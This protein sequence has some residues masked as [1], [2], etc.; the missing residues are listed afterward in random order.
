[1]DFAT[2]VKR[3]LPWI[4][5]AAT[6]NVPALIT[7]A[8]Q[9]VGEVLGVDVPADADAITTAVANATPEQLV[10]LRSREMDFK[11]RMQGLG[12]QQEREMRAFDI[13]ETKALIEDTTSARGAFGS[14]ENVFTLGC[15]I[16]SVFGLLMALVLTGCFFLMTGRVTVDSGTLAVCAGLIGTVVGYVAANAQQV[17]SFFYGS[18]KGSKDSGDRIGAALTES[19]KQQGSK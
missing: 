2:V 14:N 16:L 5:A 1:M 3:A 4:G 9:A 11:E 10:S 18:S 15:I 13:E 12:F 7:L 6:S 19:I 8:A 17:V